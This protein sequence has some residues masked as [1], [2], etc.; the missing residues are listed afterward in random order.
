MAKTESTDA[1][2]PFYRCYTGSGS[3]STTNLNR[4]SPNS[5]TSVIQ[6]S[7]LCPENNEE[8]IQFILFYSNNKCE[9]HIVNYTPSSYHSQHDGRHC[10]GLNERKFQIQVHSVW[11]WSTETVHFATENKS[12]PRFEAPHS[13]VPSVSFDVSW[14][15]LS[16][17]WSGSEHVCLRKS[18]MRDNRLHIQE[19]WQARY[20]RIDILCSPETIP[21]SNWLY[22][23]LCTMSNS[24]E[25]INFRGWPLQRLGKLNVVRVYPSDYG[26]IHPRTALLPPICSILVLSTEQLR[27]TTSCVSENNNCHCYFYY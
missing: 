14:E 6:R 9:V 5:A 19:S 1:T 26:T 23:F 12:E 17:W 8:M 27:H 10:S 22:T 15:S 7:P 20:L 21:K 16:M 11:P 13:D 4:M 24:P 25:C 18:E 2:A 3:L